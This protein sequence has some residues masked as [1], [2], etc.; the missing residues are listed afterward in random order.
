[1]KPQVVLETTATTLSTTATTTA[2][3]TTTAPTTTTP[4]TPTTTATTTTTTTTATTTAPPTT[5]TTAPSTAP[6]TAPT[7]TAPTGHSQNEMKTMP[8]ISK[9]VS[10]KTSRSITSSAGVGVEKAMMRRAEV[11]YKMKK[12]I[13]DTAI[14]AL[15]EGKSMKTISETLG[16]PGRSIKRFIAKKK[17]IEETVSTSETGGAITRKKLQRTN[18]DNLFFLKSLVLKELAYLPSDSTTKIRR[19]LAQSATLQ[20]KNWLLQNP[21][22]L[23]DQAE[24]KRLKNFNGSRSWTESVVKRFELELL[25]AGMAKAP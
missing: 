7:T 21:K 4:T 13:A 9:K 16:V 24:L 6:T 2:T 14:A 25:V 1:L 8:P 17:E 22:L 3:T 18:K 5:A 12:S 15:G 10:A 19:K 20:F 23:T 11:T